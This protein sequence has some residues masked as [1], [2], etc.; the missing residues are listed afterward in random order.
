MSKL[1]KYY[2]LPSKQMWKGRLSSKVCPNEYWHEKIFIEREG[3]KNINPNSDIGII[4]YVCDEGVKRNNGRIGAANGPKSIREQLGKLSFHSEKNVSDYGDVIC[5]ENNMENAQEVFSN[6]T[7]KIIESGQLSVGIGGGHDLAY[8]HFCGIKKALKK[9]KIGIIN[10]DAHFDL[11]PPSEKSNSG[12]PFYQILSEFNNQV[13]YLP[14][15]IQKFSNP[16]SLYK[17]ASEF[18]ID[19]I[20]IEDCTLNN[21]KNVFT[22]IDNFIQ[23]SESI[24]LSI[25]LD[26]FASYHA[27]GVSAPG[28][29]GFSVEFFRILLERILKTNKVVAIDIV[30]LN[31]IYDTDSITAKLASQIIDIAVSR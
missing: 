21:I 27:P 28:P 14:V 15:G 7:K 17:I 12:T 1:D 5:I 9:S 19:H 8:G 13:N 20:A 2:R 26:G 31:P 6:L 10:F 30:E 24:Y 18:E 16:R 4:G 11:R 22:I 3:I 25:D 23:K 29:F